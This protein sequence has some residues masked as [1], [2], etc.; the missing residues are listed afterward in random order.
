VPESPHIH[1]YI[2]AYPPEFRPVW[3]TTWFG[4]YLQIGGLTNRTVLTASLDRP[5]AVG[6]SNP[7]SSIASKALQTGHIGFR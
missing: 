1:V 4:F 3:Q 6:G 7:P 5:Q 2:G